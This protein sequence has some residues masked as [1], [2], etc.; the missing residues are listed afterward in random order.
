LGFYISH[1]VTT[2]LLDLIIFLI[3]A[4]LF[5]QPETQKNTRIALLCLFGLGLV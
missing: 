4:D 3:P 5:F 2:T 1:S